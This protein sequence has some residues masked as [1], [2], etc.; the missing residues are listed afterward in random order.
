MAIK[1]SRGSHVSFHD[2]DKGSRIVVAT[3]ENPVDLAT[4]LLEIGRDRAGGASKIIPKADISRGSDGRISAGGVGG[5]DKE[6][7]GAMV[8]ALFQMPAAQPS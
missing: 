3:G 7:I 2:G 1:G 8:D 4:D 6:V 5:N